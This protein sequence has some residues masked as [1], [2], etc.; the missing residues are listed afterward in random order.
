[1]SVSQEEAAHRVETMTGALRVQGL[2]LTHQR[3]EIVREIA[4]TDQHPDVE[5]IYARVRERV[6]TVSLDTVYRTLAALV[7]LGLV[8]RVVATSGPARYDANTQG[9]HHYICIR[10]GLVRDVVGAD[11][12]EI[13]VPGPMTEFGTVE[14]TEIQFKGVCKA[15][16][17][18]AR[19]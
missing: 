7:E 17:G 8:R 9:H 3:L 1:M 12:D 15:C 11:L 6:P 4:G 13:R 14:S 18:R 5:R 19:H 2:R 10:C 16:E